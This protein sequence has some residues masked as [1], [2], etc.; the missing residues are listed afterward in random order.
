M[1][2]SIVALLHWGLDRQ[3][4][5]KNSHQQYRIFPL[6]PNRLRRHTPRIAE[7]CGIGLYHF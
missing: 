3:E 1:F 2:R 5:M 4:L 6:L 7:G